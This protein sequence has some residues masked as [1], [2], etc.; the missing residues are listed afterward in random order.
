M[1]SG[2]EHCLGTGGMEGGMCSSVEIGKGYGYLD[3][4]SFQVG[5]QW[6]GHAVQNYFQAF[7]RH[8]L[9]LRCLR[10]SAPD[11]GAEVAGDS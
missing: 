6:R 3:H 2:H 11:R 4:G 7:H 5:N 8:F 9:R 10:A 1:A